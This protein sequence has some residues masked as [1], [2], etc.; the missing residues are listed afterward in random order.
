MNKSTEY[1]EKLLDELK[2]HCPCLKDVDLLDFINQFNNFLNFLSSIMCWDVNGGTI[3]EEERIQEIEL[4]NRLCD[5]GCLRIQPYFK[6]IV[7][8]SIEIEIRQ[9]VGGTFTT[10]KVTN[11]SY[12]KG[13]D[14]LLISPNDNGNC[15][16]A[17]ECECAC[18]CNKECK[19]NI[20][21]IKYKAGFDLTLP[22]FL[23][24]LC[25]YFSSFTA[26][27]SKCATIDDCCSMDRLAVGSYLKSKKIDL[28][29]YTWDIDKNSR[30]FL[31]NDMINKYYLNL[32]GKYA[33][34]GRDISYD[35]DAWVSHNEDNLQRSCGAKF[36]NWL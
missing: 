18:S 23:P 17:C 33:L 28:I 9:I 13:L 4:S 10:K 3:L 16:C 29:T 11:F 31:L 12:E 14:L 22:E 20:L 5:Y 30:E 35:I 26:L 36:K 21:I 2:K 1:Y 25:H 7:P 15:C 34:C 8:E 32:L 6:N 27:A 19:T 24:L